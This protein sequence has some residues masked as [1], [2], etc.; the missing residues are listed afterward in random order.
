M[1]ECIEEDE[2]Y[3]REKNAFFE[4]NRVSSTESDYKDGEKMSRNG[5]P[6]LP[7]IKRSS[8]LVVASKDTLKVMLIAFASFS[9]PKCT[10]ITFDIQVY[11]CV[12]LVVQS[13]KLVCNIVF[14]NSERILALHYLHWLLFRDIITAKV[15]AITYCQ[16]L[17]SLQTRNFK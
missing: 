5:S 7:E 12:E 2:E 15:Q 6:F 13:F 17:L 11:L 4:K 10:Q 1:L 3:E 14:V 9:K 8:T 16:S